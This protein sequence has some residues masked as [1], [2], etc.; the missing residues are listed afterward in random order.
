MI[1]REKDFYVKSASIAVPIAMQSLITIGVN[2]MDT[3]ML[4]TMGETALSASSLANQFIS[5]YQVCC[6]GIGM[7]ANVLTSRFWG[8]QDLVSLKKTVT[9]MLRLS[10]VFATIFAAATLLIPGAIMRLFTADE[11]IIYEGTRYFEWSILSYYFLGISLTLSLVLRSVGRATVPLMASIV[12]FFGNIF[13]NYMFIFGKFG[14][15]RME[16]AGAALGTL[17][18]RIIEFSMVVGYTFLKDQNIG[19]RFRD[20]FGSCRDLVG[21]YLNI[22]IPVLVSDS[23]LA[24]GNSAVAMVMGHIGAQFVSA[25]AITAVTQQLS[26]VFIQGISQASCIVVGHTL[27]TGDRKRAQDQGY[28]FLLLGVG[29][30]IVAGGIIAAIGA[31][32]ISYYRIT[33][34]T[35]GIAM[36]LMEAVAFIVIFQSANSIM[37]KGVLRGGGDTKFLMVADILFL[38]VV[39]IPLGAM[40]GLVWHFEPFWIYVC[41]KLDQVIKAVW[42]VFRLKS[43]KWIKSI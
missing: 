33:E 17:I 32:V 2:M 11:A 41:L 18:A 31:P 28:T 23:L 24:L 43:G 27:G 36:Q 13:F 16:V 38:W 25:N 8:K 26:T 12:A 6:M 15:P 19:Y 9:I 7:G 22:S 30:G 40:A 37:T 42:C 4:G 34:E 10:V 21:E 29:I 39:S 14:A 1:V 3:I 20:L 35:A 5:I